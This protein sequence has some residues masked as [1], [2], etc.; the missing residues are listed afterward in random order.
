MFLKILACA[1]NKIDYD[2]R[3]RW[4]GH[5]ACAEE[6]KNVYYILAAKPERK[7][8]HGIPRRR[9][10]DNIRLD[11]RETGWEGVDC[12]HLIHDTDQ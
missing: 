11:L 10:E 8:P 3:L 6:M 2:R 1:Q 12:T 4:T 9:Q 7:R 5:V